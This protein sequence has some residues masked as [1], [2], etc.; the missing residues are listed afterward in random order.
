M[1]QRSRRFMMVWGILVLAGALV[2]IPLME[3]LDHPEFTRPILTAI[4]SLAIVVIIYPELYQRLWFWIT[5]MVFAALHLPPIILIHWNAGWV[6][7]PFIFVFCLAD[8]AIM[9]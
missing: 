4:I 5:M 9:I 3:R 1:A 7:S 8:V 6:P 2:T